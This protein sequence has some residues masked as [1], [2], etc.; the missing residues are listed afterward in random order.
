MKLLLLYRP[1]S[2]HARAVDNFLREMH[3]RSSQEVELVDV[4][5]QEGV[6]KVELYDAMQYP[7]VVATTD[8]GQL[9]KMW[10]GTPLPMVNDVL[11]FLAH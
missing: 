10:S 1:E 3:A 5:S 8:D 9:Q 11:G 2:E 7:T 4:D 6:R